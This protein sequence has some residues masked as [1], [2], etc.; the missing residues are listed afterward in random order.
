MATKRKGGTEKLSVSVAKND[1]GVL[2]ARARKLY[3]GNLSAVIAEAAARIREEEGRQELL[4]W[5][6][7]GEHPPTAAER[8]AALAELLGNLKPK[9]RGRAA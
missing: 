6:Q 5:L 8:Q 2:R 7:D 4:A 9:R 1:I 3:A